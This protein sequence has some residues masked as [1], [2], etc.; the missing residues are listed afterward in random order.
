VQPVSRL[1]AAPNALWLGKPD[2]KGD[3]AQTQTRIQ[4][5]PFRPIDALATKPCV[6]RHPHRVLNA[7][8]K[9]ASDRSAIRA[10][11]D[12]DTF[13]GTLLTI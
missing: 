6:G 12:R 3:R 7:K 9:C 1:N 4:E 11:S 10:I 13:S 8:E 5:Q 2:R